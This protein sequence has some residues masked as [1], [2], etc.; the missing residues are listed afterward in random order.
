LQ[1]CE[2]ETTDKTYFENKKDH[3]IKIV[4]RNLCCG[5]LDS[6]LPF[7]NFKVNEITS[8]LIWVTEIDTN[9]IDQKGMDK[10]NMQ[11]MK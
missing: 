10:I 11:R 7:I 1:A 9:K 8:Q 3:S 4:E 6:D 2:I 5:A